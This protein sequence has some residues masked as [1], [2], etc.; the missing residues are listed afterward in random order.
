MN[1]FTVTPA[2][3]NSVFVINKLSALSVSVV[4]DDLS[5]PPPGKAKIRFFH[6][7]PDAPALNIYLASNPVFPAPTTIPASA[8][9]V[10]TNRIFNDQNGT[11]DNQT[12]VT[13]PIG[14]YRIEIRSTSGIVMSTISLPSQLLEDGRIYTVYVRGFQTPPTGNNNML[15]TKVLINY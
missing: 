11:P 6:L 2:V 7:S 3:N 9:P 8:K 13:V 4:T 14:Y 1:G 5:A 10:F 12:F 15:S